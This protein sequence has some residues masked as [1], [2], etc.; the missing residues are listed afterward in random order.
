[1]QAGFNLLSW[2][3]GNSI[4][5][6]IIYRHQSIIPVDSRLKIS[7]RARWMGQAIAICTLGSV[8][9]VYAAYTFD[10]SE[11]DRLLRQSRYNISWVASRGPYYIH[12]KS[13]VVMIV[14]CMAETKLCKS[15]KMVSD[16]LS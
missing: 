12:E 16:F 10:R 8:P 2:L 9:I 7:D 5:A 3:V 11:M 13:T 1:I 4:L 14:L 15:V 6:C